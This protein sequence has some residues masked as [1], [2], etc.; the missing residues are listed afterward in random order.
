M[1]IALLAVMLL[2]ATVASLLVIGAEPPRLGQQPSAAGHR[3]GPSQSGARPRHAIRVRAS[4]S[5]RRHSPAPRFTA[6][7]ATVSNYRKS[8]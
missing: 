2:G 4:L 6:L 8:T 5:W 1:G 3:V 7:G